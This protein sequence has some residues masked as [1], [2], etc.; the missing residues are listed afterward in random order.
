M[1]EKIVLDKNSFMALA[2]ENRIKLLKKLDERRMTIT[3]LSRE[4]KISKPA[5]LKHL[6][7]L[8]DAGLVKK[9]EGERKW[10]YYSLTL[11]GKHILH[12]ERTKITL[13]LSISF[14]SMAGAIASLW[15]YFHEKIIYTAD[16]TM[17]T[18]V[19][20]NT[21]KVSN[22]IISR[23]SNFLQFSI[24]LWIVSISFI[25]I[26]IYIWRNRTKSSFI[27]KNKQKIFEI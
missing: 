16:E 2:S 14:I 12:P 15:K 9:N 13:L 25:V 22:E 8:I 4:L 18:N 7:K 26:A 17:K 20:G 10:V 11:K 21:S 19:Y 5:I 27:S 3:E 6:T 1:N 23:N 24:V